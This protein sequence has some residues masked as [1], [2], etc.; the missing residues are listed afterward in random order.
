VLEVLG[1]AVY[2]NGTR[3]RS[4]QP[5]YSG[6]QV[7]TGRESG[8]IVRFEDGGF[9]Q[10]DA[11]T[12]PRFEL[13][14]KGMDWFLRVIHGVGQGLAE[15]GETRLE[16]QTAQGMFRQLGTR[17]NL[18]IGPD[19]ATLTVL[20][21]RMELRGPQQIAVGE[22][23]QLRVSHGRVEQ[24]RAL[25]AREL[26]ET[27]QWHLESVRRTAWCCAQGEVRRVP[28]TACERRGGVAYASEREALRACRRPPP[29]EDPPGWCCLRGEVFEAPR[30]ECLGA[31]GLIF[32]LRDR[33]RAE[34]ACR[35]RPP[36]VP[37]EEPPVRPP[38]EP[39]PRPPTDV[40]PRID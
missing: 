25:S 5:I 32:A 8:A 19:H 29:R 9:W 1:P 18:L 3:G 2:V 16:V 13:V 11:E 30:S 35:D 38:R 21:G 27:L 20:R 15:S 37:P 12:D 24:L 33:R 40:R 39:A 26:E 28:A 14:R 22:G 17:F 36:A 4:G 7:S 34:E 31:G 10:L 6:D 23:M